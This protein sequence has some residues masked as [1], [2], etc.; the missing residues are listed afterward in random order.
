MNPCSNKLCN[1]VPTTRIRKKIPKQ[2]EKNGSMCTYSRI[3]GCI[4]FSKTHICE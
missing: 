1:N 4:F 2:I 3:Y